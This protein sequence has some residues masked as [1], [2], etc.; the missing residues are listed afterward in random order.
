MQVEHILL[1]GEGEAPAHHPAKTLADGV[2]Q[3]LNMRSFSG[4]FA[5]FCVRPNWQAVVR[6]PKVAEAVAPEIAVG[7]LPPKPPAGFHRAVADEEGQYL[8]CFPA[9]R[10]PDAHLVDLRVD[11]G[12]NLV[13]FDHVRGVCTVNGLLERA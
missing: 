1:F 12:E 2:V 4:F 5:D 13:N 6:A 3:P 9:Q 8:A 10:Y 7:Q 11:A